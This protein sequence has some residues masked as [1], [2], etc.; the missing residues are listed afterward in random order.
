MELKEL[1]RLNIKRY[2][3]SGAKYIKDFPDILLFLSSDAQ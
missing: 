3:G 1:S 2:D